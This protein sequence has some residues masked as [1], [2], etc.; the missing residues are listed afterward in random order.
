MIEGAQIDWAAHA[1]NKDEFFFRMKGF[2]LAVKEVLNYVQK[3]KNTLL[4]ITADH[5]T[6]GL[7]IRDGSKEG[8][9]VLDFSTNG[10]TGTMVPVFAYGPGAEYFRGVMQN[11]DIFKIFT[12]LLDI[13]TGP[14]MS[15]N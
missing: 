7:S 2:E 6:G 4:V 13:P 3:D 9:V 5:A 8:D 11:T 15:N 12:I 10:H 1:G 14:Q